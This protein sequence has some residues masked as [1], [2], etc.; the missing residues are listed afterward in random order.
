VHQKLNAIA[1]A[2]ADLMADT[3]D[4]ADRDLR[5]DLQELRAAVGLEQREG[6]KR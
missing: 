3:A 1:D 2:L 5:R 6:S 4:E